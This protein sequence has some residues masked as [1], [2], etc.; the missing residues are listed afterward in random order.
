MESTNQAKV[1]QAD[2]EF[3][4]G[5]AAVKTSM[6]KWSA[7]HITGSMNFEEAAK[8]YKQA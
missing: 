6:L 7:D 1:K 2:K 5:K 8:L 3:K 4:K